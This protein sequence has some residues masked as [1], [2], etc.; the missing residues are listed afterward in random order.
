[1]NVLSDAEVSA[2]QSISVHTKA[3][4]GSFGTLTKMRQRLFRRFMNMF[5]GDSPDPLTYSQLQIL[6]SKHQRCDC[7]GTCHHCKHIIEDIWRD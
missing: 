1:M 5:Q 6:V 4:A 2:V 7:C 3:G